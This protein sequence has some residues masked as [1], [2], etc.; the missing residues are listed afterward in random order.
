MSQH[1][2]RADS[3]GRGR[4]W[5]ASK[6]ANGELESEVLAALWAQGRPLTVGEV[7]DALASDLA[8]QTVLTTLARLHAKGVVTR[9]PAG[10]GHAYTPVLDEAAMSAE[11]M[12]ALLGE[13]DRARVFQHFVDG[14]DPADE[15]ALRAA[16]KANR[17]G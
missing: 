12:R 15:A 9:Q 6:R 13:V 8:Y 7:Q 5:V 11:R 10:R 2:K 14:L 3:S 4:K 1:D 16:F 17:K